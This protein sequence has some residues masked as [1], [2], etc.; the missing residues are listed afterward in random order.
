MC[1]LHLVQDLPCQILGRSCHEKLDF[2]KL[3]PL[4][5]L[6]EDQPHQQLEEVHR[7]ATGWDPLSVMVMVLL[8]STSTICWPASWI[9]A[10]AKLY[11]DAQHVC[12]IFSCLVVI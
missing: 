4:L 8:I 12:L 11:A 3:A 7:L 5:A 9:P 1:S 2:L 6:R 10:F